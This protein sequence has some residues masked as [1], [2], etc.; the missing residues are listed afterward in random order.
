ESM[1]LRQMAVTINDQVTTLGCFDPGSEIVTMREELYKKLSGVQ[2]R[3][4]DAV[5]MISANDNIDPTTGLIDAL[6]LRI[7]GIQFY[8]KVH[9]VPKSPAPLIIGMPFWAMADTR[10]DIY[11][12]GFTS[13]TISDPN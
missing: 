13:L 12:D 11:P 7:G 2:L 4:D 1:P 3:A 8:A 6:P 10:I 5:P 9:V